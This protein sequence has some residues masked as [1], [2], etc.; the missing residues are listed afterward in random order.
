ME[1]I[2][3]I[4]DDF[5]ELTKN[6]P[7][8]RSVEWLKNRRVGFGGSE[9]AALKNVPAFDDL[10]TVVK[11]KLFSDMY[12]FKANAII[13]FGVVFEDSTKLICEDLF[14]CDINDRF[15]S[16]PYK[17]IDGL[18]YSP[19]GI[20]AVKLIT[21]NGLEALI[22]L[23]EFKSVP[24]SVPSGIIPHKYH[25]QISAGKCMLEIIDASIY[26]EVAYRI[27]E[28][29]DFSINN[30][31]YNKSFHCSDS[32]NNNL[33]M[34]IP[35]NKLPLILSMLVFTCSSAQRNKYNMIES[36]EEHIL[37]SNMFSELLNTDQIPTKYN[38][39]LDFISHF[40][41]DELFVGEMGWHFID[42]L[43]K[44]NINGLL[45][46]HHL[47]PYVIEERLAEIPFLHEQ[48]LDKPLEDM[49]Y[50]DNEME[51]YMIKQVIKIRKSLKPDERIACILPWKAMKM[52]VVFEDG[53]DPNYLDDIKDS[54]IDIVQYLKSHVDAD[55][56]EKIEVL[57]ILFGDSRINRDKKIKNM[58]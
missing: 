7:P 37:D 22:I 25:C 11:K 4:I 30:S 9:I 52:S 32:K 2:K 18:G 14:Q 38:P 29:S 21:K 20:G 47:K 53:F 6:L 12:E 13:N 39:E 33:N 5:Y 16:I 44:Y 35:E 51:Q 34:R 27:C 15:P 54:I 43:L 45:N 57:R 26:A 42:R 24:R 40:H 1:E 46:V 49:E 31:N 56:E 19:D 28:V 10:Y 3:K 23:F 17:K 8:Q 48:G 55:N 36:E 58:I 50:T 41:E